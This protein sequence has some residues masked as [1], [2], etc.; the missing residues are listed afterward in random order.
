MI[1]EHDH[2]SARIVSRRKV[3]PVKQPLKPGL[4]I[5]CSPGSELFV[6]QQQGLSENEFTRIR[7]MQQER[8][9]FTIPQPDGGP[10]E[11]GITQDPG[12]S[13]SYY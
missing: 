9:R 7:A 3:V 6:E 11:N 13:L 12:N 4:F 1:H 2:S 10:T 8:A 5:K